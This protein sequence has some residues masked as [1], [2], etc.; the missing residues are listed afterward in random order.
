MTVSASTNRWPFTGN[1][2]TTEFSIGKVYAAA[3][4]TVY[5]LD[6]D[7]A[8]TTQ[9]LNTHY[10]VSLLGTSA[11]K[12][13]M[14]TAPATGETLLVIRNQPLLQ[15]T[16]IKNQGAFL[17]EIHEDVFDKLFM[18]IA[19]LWHRLTRSV[20]Q[21][22][23]SLVDLDLELPTPSAGRAIGWND[24]GD[25]LA[26]IA[27]LS[28]VGLPLVVAEGGTGATTPAGARTNLLNAELNSIAG[29]TSAA[30]KLPYYTGSGTAA[31][32]DFTAGGRALVNS[33]GT[34]DTF[35]YFSALNTVTL[36]SITAAG[37]A[38]LDDA[39]VAAQ[40]VTL[41]LAVASQAT[42]EAGSDVTTAALVT[43]GR[44]HFHPSAAKGWLKAGDAGNILASY[45]ITSLTDTGTGDVAVTIAND[46]SGVHYAVPTGGERTSSTGT[47]T[48]ARDISAK[49]GSLA[50]GSFSLECW[51]KTATTNVIKDPASWH[52]AIFGDL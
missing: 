39:N 33:A 28:G 9:T 32:A 1:D 2:V 29:L 3:D 21:S 52:C 26:N 17:P 42:Q 18:M 23:T 36:A 12:V 8:P 51:D 41:G 22:D 49:T 11:A 43:S 25:G 35:P 7:D 47:A 31:L 46:L 20:H 6:S 50:A 30:N 37:R 13:T 48:L 34:A 16:D 45:N 24:D 4:V 44:Q 27:D 10:S 40:L 15:N 14:V 19:R 5:L 38:L